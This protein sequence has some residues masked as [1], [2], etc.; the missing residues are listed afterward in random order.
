MTA[1]TI[2]VASKVF[3][4]PGQQAAWHFLHVPAKE[5]EAI[6]KKHGAHARGWGSLRVRATIGKT[7]WDTS[8][9]PDKKS[10]T[11]LLPLKLSVRRAEG[12]AA[13]DRV[14]VSLEIRVP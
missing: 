10:G 5:S 6:K 4:W 11:Y 1:R 9:F 7:S 2:T 14:R 12:I 3:L 8:I 13:N